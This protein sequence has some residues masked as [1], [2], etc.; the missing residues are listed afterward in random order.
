MNYIEYINNFWA[1]HEEETFCT[2]DI[3]LY[4][5]LLK[6]NNA[7]GW[8]SIFRRNNSKIEADLGISYNTLRGSRERLMSANLLKYVSKNGSSDVTYTLTSSKFDEVGC[9]VTNEVGSE[10]GSEV[11]HEVITPKDKL[12]KTKQNKTKE[13]NIISETT[14][15]DSEITKND[16]KKIEQKK[17]NS[18]YSKFV[19]IWFLF[20][21]EKYNFKPS[22]KSID[23]NKIKS[24]M[25]KI[26]KLY[27]NNEN[28]LTDEVAEKL[29]LKFLILAYSDDWIK[30]NF[31]LQILD[32]KFDTI[33]QKK[34]NN[35][36]GINNT[37]SKPSEM[38]NRKEQLLRGLHG[39]Q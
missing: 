4:F 24:I 32:S 17:E 36:K 10:V 2:T 5:Y 18:I 31:Q 33:I 26:K 37:K 16:F 19:E 9:D 28:N 27:L 8:K 20:H 7:C 25:E 21:E 6:V 12:N 15:S 22:F 11:T 39:S 29:F 30:S 38:A 3:S 1:I 23:G 13:N 35:D 34:I 14:V